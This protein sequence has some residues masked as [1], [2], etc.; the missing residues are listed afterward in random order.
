MAEFFESVGHDISTFE[1][2][3]R[4]HED[5]AFIAR[6]RK[7][8]EQVATWAKRSAIMAVVSGVLYV[9]WEGFRLLAKG[10]GQ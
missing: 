9:L 3:D 10:V 1:G 5:F 7:G 4:L 8:S 2:R 6:Q